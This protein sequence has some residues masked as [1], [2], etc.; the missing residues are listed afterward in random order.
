MISG[1][2]GAHHCLSPEP[3]RVTISEVAGHLVVGSAP[4]QD[5]ASIMQLLGYQPERLGTPLRQ[6]QRLR[7][8]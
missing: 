1:V 7:A 4:P 5:Q 2:G 8:S 3:R 6:V